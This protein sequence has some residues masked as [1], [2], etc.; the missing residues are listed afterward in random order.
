MPKIIK[1]DKEVSATTTVISPNSTDEVVSLYEKRINQSISSKILATQKDEKLPTFTAEETAYLQKK[2]GEADG[3]SEV[4]VITA[5]PPITLKKGNKEINIK[6]APS[7]VKRMEKV[8]APHP[9]PDVKGVI[10]DVVK[11]G[12]SGTNTFVDEASKRSAEDDYSAMNRKPTVSGRN[13]YE[14]RADIL[15]CAASVVELAGKNP[16][17]NT[18]DLSDEILRVASKFYDFVENKRYGRH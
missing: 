7:L 1:Q 3:L 18:D 13:A 6:N 4:E 11:H 12:Q 10:G 8:L 14:I 5:D 16:L 9:S 2:S 17:R 15:E